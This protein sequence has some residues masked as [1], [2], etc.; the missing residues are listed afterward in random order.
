LAANGNPH[1][2]AEVIKR[3][4]SGA[5]ADIGAPPTP[6]VLARMVPWAADLEVRQPAWRVH[7]A[8]E[9]VPLRPAVDMGCGWPRRLDPF[10]KR[11]TVLAS[12]G[13]GRANPHRG[14]VESREIR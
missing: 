10:A 12:I 1:L 11:A 9:Q 14:A 7:A 3:A 13:A 5:A 6:K 2:L 8:F 4:R